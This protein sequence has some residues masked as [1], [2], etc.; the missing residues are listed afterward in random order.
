MRKISLVD[1]QEYIKLFWLNLC[2][3]ATHT[4][5]FVIEVYRYYKDLDFAKQD[6]YLLSLYFFT[7]PYAISRKFLKN[8]HAKDIYTYG[9]TPLTTLEKIFRTCGITHKDTVFELGCGTGRGCFWLQRFIGCKVVGIE[10]IPLFVARANQTKEK[11]KVEKVT[12]LEQNMF[13]TDYR[14]ATCIYLYGTCLERVEIQQLIAKFKT[15]PQGTRIISVSYPLTDYDNGGSF[16]VM[17]RFPAQ[18]TW[19]IADIYLQIRT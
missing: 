3:K 8:L 13:S 4:K 7:S 5:E 15:L 14:K 17:Q 1:V 11:F 18:F 19:G 6:L 12:F 10:Y 9:E 2:V 16:E